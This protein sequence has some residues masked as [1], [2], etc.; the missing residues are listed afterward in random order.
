ME[1]LKIRVD[2]ESESIEAQNLFFKLGFGFYNGANKISKTLEYVGT[3][4]FFAYKDS[5]DLTHTGDGRVFS[6]KKHKEITLPQLRDLVVLKRND[7]GDA[8]HACDYPSGLGVK[9]SGVWYAYNYNEKKWE[10]WVDD[11]EYKVRDFKPI[12]KKQM[13]EEATHINEDGDYWKDVKFNADGEAY[14]GGFLRKG[15]WL[16][17]GI[18]KLKLKPI[19]QS[20]NDIVKS[21]EEFRVSQEEYLAKD[22]N[23]EYFAFYSTYPKASEW[24]EVPEGAEE[25][26]GNSLFYKNNGKEF[27][28][29]E[30]WNTSTYGDFSVLWQ[31][32]NP[33][34]LN[35]IGFDLGAEGGD[36]TKIT[37]IENPLFPDFELSE[38]VIESNDFNGLDKSEINH[39]VAKAF[40][41]IRGTDLNE[42]DIHFLRQLIDLT[43]FHYWDR[44]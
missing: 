18:N 7:V 3:T 31:R 25:Y 36:E 20:L 32:E 1:S 16:Q 17:S 35:S 13:S 11:S 19:P 22:E 21:A 40:N 23:G 29:G 34:G 39:R 2:S 30:N 37:T 14:C 4:Y 9:L 43:T 44:K 28:N 15:I 8:T 26:R 38:P 24:I 41:V 42:D 33:E 5:L 27:F 10:L 12:E 6:D